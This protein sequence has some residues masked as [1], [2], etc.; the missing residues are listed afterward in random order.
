VWFWQISW[1]ALRKCT[2]SRGQTMNQQGNGVTTVIVAAIALSFAGCTRVQGTQPDQATALIARSASQKPQL[3]PSIQTAAQAPSS[4]PSTSASLPLASPPKSDTLPP[5]VVA[6]DRNQTLTVAEHTFRLLTHLQ[7]IETTQTTD[8]TVEWWELRNAKDQIVY[9]QAYPVSFLDGGFETTVAI[10]AIPFTTQ[11][12]SG[13][14]VQGMEL[15]SAPG[16]GG[17]LQVFGFK[18][19]R[20]KYGTDESLFGPFGAPISIEGEFLD[21]GTDALPSTPTFMAGASITTMH[22]ILRFRVWAGNFSILYPVLI[23]WITGKLQPAWRCIETTSK[24]PS[25]RC[26]YTTEIEAHRDT[27][28]TF[29]RLFPEA[30]DS[31]TPKHVVVQ[32]AT[33]VEYLEAKVPVRWSE[34]SKSISFSV[35]GEVW[36][37]IRINGQEGWIHSEEDF[38]SVGLPQAG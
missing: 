15:P 4:L 18:Y 22:D 1:H 2:L 14:L 11:Q 23:N 5:K 6:S 3:P 10:S 21:I 12:G 27:Q 28:M 36:L 32:P 33:K 29:V 20:D 24:G 26:S 8:E 16:S 37:K 7:L 34:D 13:I 25:Q 31:F 9:R 19:G 17:W 35:N 38:E 30:D